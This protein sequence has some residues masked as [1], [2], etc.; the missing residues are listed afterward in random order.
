[1]KRRITKQPF[2]Y[3]DNGGNIFCLSDQ[4]QRWLNQYF[5]STDSNGGKLPKLV[6]QWIRNS[7]RLI[8]S[9]RK[10]SRCEPFIVRKDR[11][12]LVFQFPCDNAHYSLLLLTEGHVNGDVPGADRALTSRE[13]EVLN[14]IC[15]GKTNPEIATILGISPRTV[16]KHVERILEKL[17]VENRAAAIANLMKGPQRPAKKKLRL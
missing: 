14:W 16:H 12:F 7:R 3:F 15:S 11:R 13:K 1:M 5:T 4:A 6:Q 17:G 10:P 9:E 2:I 8:A